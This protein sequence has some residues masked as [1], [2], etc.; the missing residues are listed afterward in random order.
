MN[1]MINSELGIALAA[2]FAAISIAQGQ[3]LR[4]NTALRDDPQKFGLSDPLWPYMSTLPEEWDIRNIDG[5]NLAS[6]A[7]NQL[8]CGSCWAH[9][10]SSAL[11]DR[12]NLVHKGTIASVNLAPQVLMNCIKDDLG[13]EGGDQSDAYKWI[14]R[15][16]G[17]PDET[18]QPYRAEK[19]KHAGKCAEHP[20]LVCLN[21]IDQKQPLHPVRN[22]LRYGIVAHGIVKGEEHI[23]QALVQGGPLAC[24][25]CSKGLDNYAGGVWQGVGK[26]CNDHSI[27]IAGYGTTSDG[28]PYWVVRNSWGSFWGEE[29]WLRIRRGNNTANIE[30]SCAWALPAAAVTHE[31]MLV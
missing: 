24:D 23:K 20:I 9:A 4:P 28:V 11:A 1:D 29:G 15:S 10:A 5:L 25:I 14:E 7:R 12:I 3:G 2:L 31:N 19:L 6:P 18:C 16:E 26:L 21:Q 13:C 17:L 8:E 27:S 22:F 30:H